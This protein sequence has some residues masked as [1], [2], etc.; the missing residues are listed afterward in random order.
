VIVSL[1]VCPS[2]FSRTDVLFRP[3]HVGLGWSDFED[4]VQIAAAYR[5]GADYLNTRKPKDFEGGLIDV[6]QPGEFL[7]LLRAP[8][9]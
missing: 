1:I 5:A 3:L 6:V 7:A 2:A 8:K 9:E 4:A